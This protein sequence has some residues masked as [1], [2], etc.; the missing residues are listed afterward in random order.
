MSTM[1]NVGRTWPAELDLRG[2]CDR[3]GWHILPETRMRFGRAPKLASHW[4]YR[5][6]PPHRSLTYNDTDGKMILEL[7]CHGKDG[8]LGMQTVVLGKPAQEYRIKLVQQEASSAESETSRR[9]PS[10]AIRVYQRW[11]EYVPQLI[12]RKESCLKDAD[13]ATRNDPGPST[14]VRCSLS[15][16]CE[17]L[18]AESGNNIRQGARR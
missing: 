10:G 11:N 2:I 6:G 1:H 15:L 12:S 5:M 14:I 7:R 17:S 18:A 16:A 3:Y 13:R 9:S 4:F 8:S